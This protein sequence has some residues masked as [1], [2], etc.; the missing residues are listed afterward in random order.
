MY[1]QQM[2][3]DWPITSSLQCEPECDETEFRLRNSK[4]PG[5]DCSLEALFLGQAA[6]RVMAHRVRAQPRR[7]SRFAF[8]PLAPRT[9]LKSWLHFG[10]S[11]ALGIFNEDY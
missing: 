4:E 3:W 2:E 9:K 11:M 10:T 7:D 6:D 1:M 5:A 8:H